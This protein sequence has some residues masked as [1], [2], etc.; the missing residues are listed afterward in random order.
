MIS[1]NQYQD[2]EI[3]QNADFTNVIT[4]PLLGT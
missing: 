2:I 1:A 3:Q 4:L